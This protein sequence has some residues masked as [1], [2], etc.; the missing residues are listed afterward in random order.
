MHQCST[1]IAQPTRLSHL[2]LPV[3][4]CSPVKSCSGDNG[5]EETKGIMVKKD[6]T[7]GIMVT[8][9]KS[10]DVEETK[11]IMV[12]PDKSSMAMSSY[13]NRNELNGYVEETKGI[14]D[15]AARL[16]RTAREAHERADEMEVS[17]KLW[18]DDC[19][20]DSNDEQKAF[21][22]NAESN[23]NGDHE[24]YWHTP[25]D[26][27]LGDDKCLT[28]TIWFDDDW[29]ANEMH[30]PDGSEHWDGENEHANE[31]KGPDSEHWDCEHEHAKEQ[32]GPDSEQWD[33][34]H[35]RAKEQ[36]GPDSEHERANE[37]KGPDSEPWDCEDWDCEQKQKGPDSEH[38]DC[39]QEQKDPDSEHWDTNE[40]RKPDDG[41][42]WDCEHDQ[43]VAYLDQM[44]A[45]WRAHKEKMLDK[46]IF[47][48]TTTE[49]DMATGEI[50][51]RTDQMKVTRGMA[52]ILK[53]L[54]NL[55][56]NKLGDNDMNKPDDDNAS[57]HN[58]VIADQGSQTKPKK[59]PRQ[60]DHHPPA[61]LLIV[62]DFQTTAAMVVLKNA[63]GAEFVEANWG[64]DGRPTKRA[65]RCRRSLLEYVDAWTTDAS[66]WIGAWGDTLEASQ[67][68]QESADT[69]LALVDEQWT[70]YCDVVGNNFT[71]GLDK[72]FPEA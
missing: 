59:R 56:M 33:C 30:K 47:I 69:Y 40:M 48:Y 50:I 23:E 63:Y 19:N 61:E 42:H 35:E 15:E 10:S 7:K 8:P 66:A 72:F 18:A 38:W 26:K 13:M 21:G 32:K 28:M 54:G 22:D 52:Q 1:T 67:A 29:Y 27:N 11:G 71:K 24:M 25:E 68:S 12:T 14:M 44:A 9:V 55:E 16:L 62:N 37:Q 31:Q 39:E 6:E 64:T 46:N 17:R 20:H 49:R 53:N 5:A 3:M 36:K 2:H 65:R 43:K 41:E 4:A 51:I 57:D 45:N 58:R 34:E 70:D 60:P